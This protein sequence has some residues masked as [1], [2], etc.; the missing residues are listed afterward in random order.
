MIKKT[1]QKIANL[2]GYQINKLSTLPV[3][4]AA[5]YSIFSMINALKRCQDKQI[6][7]NTV[8][9]VGASDGR[10]SEDCMKSYPNAFYHLIEAQEG[11][12]AG[13]EYFKQRHKNADYIL[14]AAGNRVGNIYFDNSGLFAGIASD[15]PF[16]GNCI[17]VPVTTI[18]EEVK[19]K[20]LQGPYLIKLDTHGFEIPILEGAKESLKQ[21]NLLI[22][23]VYNFQIAKDSLRFWEMC[24]YIEKLGF[25][26]IEVVDFMLRKRDN[27]FWQMDIFFI[28]NDRQ[29]FASNDYQ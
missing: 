8:I 12:Q 17:T 1:V 23:E 7:I 29:E 24:A 16:E 22:I 2:F 21:A 15:T 14:A 13:L 27:A 18:D 4:E 28:K 26:P 6:L 5:D 11:H 20:N 10:W 3:I 9:D 19:K 25:R